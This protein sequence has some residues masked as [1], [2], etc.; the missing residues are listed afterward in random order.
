MSPLIRQGHI[1]ATEA[2]VILATAVGGKLLFISRTAAEAAATAG[3]MLPLINAVVAFLFFCLAVR[4]FD[5]ESSEGLVEQY[6]RQA[7]LL[8][9][10]LVLAVALDFLLLEGLTIRRFGAETRTIILPTTPVIFIEL[11]A[12]IAISYAAALGIESLGRASMLYGVPMAITVLALLVVAIA[13]ARPGNLLPLLGNGLRP[14]LYSGTLGGFYRELWVLLAMWPYLRERHQ[15]L[16]I[17]A[18]GVAL[19]GVLQSLVVAVTLAV[20]AMPATTRLPF[21]VAE[22][23][24]AAQLGE[25]ISN[26]EAVFTFLLAFVVLLHLS[27]IYWTVLLLMADLLRIPNYRQLVPIASMAVLAASLL[28]KGLAETLTLGE[29][30]RH[31]GSLVIYPLLVV[32]WLVTLVKRRRRG[33]GKE[34][35]GPA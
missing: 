12:F 19:T 16:R 25:Y 18:I 7:G 24:R 20:I 34:A 1:G 3:W 26:L 35:G 11:V 15:M 6:E 29:Q 27:M 5:P 33:K 32:V 28:P 13:R 31:F 2:T 22:I 30:I 17:G 8:G 21:P 10:L 9:T 4:V 14:L 23:A